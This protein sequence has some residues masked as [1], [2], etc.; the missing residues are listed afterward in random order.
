MAA[1][2]GLHCS[3][4]AAGGGVPVL[5]F[6][7]VYG[8]VWVTEHIVEVVITSAVCSVL[9]VAAVLLLM[10]WANRRDERRGAAWRALK[11][12]EAPEVVTVTAT[13]VGHAERAALGFRDLHIHI[14]GV[15]SAEQA[16]V[17]RQALNGRTRQ[18]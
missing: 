12:A 3:G 11:A 14:D 7:A 10:R 4:C 18:S 13:P 17:I 1:C 8:F 2:S 6:G 16:A 9:A 5:A 15:P